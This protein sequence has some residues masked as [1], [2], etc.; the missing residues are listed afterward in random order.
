MNQEADAPRGLALKAIE[1]L[2][3][4]HTRRANDIRGCVGLGSTA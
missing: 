1:A 2:H 4:K 3:R